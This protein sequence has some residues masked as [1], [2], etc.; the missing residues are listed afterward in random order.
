MTRGVK[1]PLERNTVA[2][3]TGAMASRGR[4]NRQGRDT[5]AGEGHPS[6]RDR[7]TAQATVPG[8]RQATTNYSDVTLVY[9]PFPSGPLPG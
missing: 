4:G 5:V 9:S 6:S 1:A 2:A 7:I 8:S 3:Q